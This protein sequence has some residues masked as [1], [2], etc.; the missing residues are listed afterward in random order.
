MCHAYLLMSQS[1]VRE[2]KSAVK[3]DKLEYVKS[4]WE[5][6][7]FYRFSCSGSQNILRRPTTVADIFK[8]I[9]PPSKKCLATSLIYIYIYIYIYT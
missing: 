8:G 4:Y 3:K 9:E 6:S 7:E 5:G 1:R 2:N